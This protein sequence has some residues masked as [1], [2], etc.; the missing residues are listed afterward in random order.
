MTGHERGFRL[1]LRLLPET[2]RQAYGEEMTELFLGRLGRARAVGRRQVVRLWIRTGL[3]VVRTAAAER[4]DGS[5]GAAGGPAGAIRRGREG[6]ME[7]LAQD[8]R[9][10]ARRLARTP[11]FTLAA[12]A[13]LAMGIGANAAAFALVDGLLFRPPPFPRPAELVRV[14]QDGDDGEPS[15]T[16]FP[17]YRDM[18]AA[19]DVFAAVSATSPDVAAWEG[20]EGPRPVAVEYATA[21]HF[22]VLG[23]EPFRGR[24]F[25]ASH[26][27]P[28][29][30]N[31]AVV[32]HW[33]WTHR[34]GADPGVLGSTVRINGQPVTVIGVGP[35]G[36][37][38]VGQALVT[39]FWL[40][41]SSAGVGGP[42][43]IANLDRREDHWYDVSARLAPGATPAA[44]QAAMDALAGRLAEAW[45][46]LNRGRDITVFR[47]GEVRL[48]PEFDG[49][50]RAAGLGLLVVVGLV[51]V[52]ACSNLANLLLVRGLARSSE[53]AV[54][55][56]LG[57]GRRRVARL[58]LAE[59]LLL[60]GLGGAVGLGVAAALVGALPRLPLPLPGGAALDVPLDGRFL[61]FAVAL[62]LAT[63]VLFGLAPALRSTRMDPAGAL[64]EVRS[65]G[66]G[67]TVSLVRA[68][69]V[70]VQVAVSVVLVVG[71]AL[72]A[73][74]LGS[75]SSVEPGFDVERLAMIGTNLAQGGLS[76]AE[77]P[78]VA[79]ELVRRVA[80]LPGVDRVALTSRLPVQAGGSTTTVIEGYAPPSGTGAV[81]LPFAVVS[82]D[83]FETMGIRRLAGRGFG[84]DDRPGSP[85]VVVVNET[86]ARRF[87]GGDAVGGR[88][89]PEGQPNAWR[90]VVG[91]VADVKVSGLQEPPTPML[92]MAAAQSAPAAFTV[93][94]RTDGDPAA[95]APALRRALGAVRPGLPV[96]RLGTLDD[97]LGRALVG[98]RAV[99]GLLGTF[100]LLALLLASLGIY[101]VVAFSVARRAGEMGIRV[102][103]GAPRR[104]LVRM[105][106]REALVP[107]AAGLAVG[108]AAA[109][110]AAR[111]MD[112]LLF[113][114]DAL[115]PLAFG[116][117]L[118]LLLAA[119]ILASWLPARRAAGADPL[120]ALRAR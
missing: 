8:V 43:R 79:E 38:G 112:A 98:P 17:A 93:V 84:P 67:R 82:G 1:L 80:A 36:Y 2:F 85:S 111:L 6:T 48:H 57:A 25:D 19:T 91:V 89:R 90:E 55:R 10:A 66:G 5:D 88:V 70:G 96:T 75:A 78:V 68:T 92:Y 41:I 94:A 12:V 26:D 72:M 113:G 119:A 86:A 37:G 23:I 100:S 97:H 35:Q 65:P 117:G 61:A 114:V 22:P 20:P 24:W 45:P 83:Y 32:S 54:R 87:W 120:E 63:G 3:D 108:L 105:V 29:A 21:S 101:A 116:G 76:A 110:A 59:S 18:A 52:L 64:R 53:V 47:F 107:V 31:V 77:A 106:L 118:A 99:T 16:S 71:A 34:M 28:G 109:V 115:D 33:T 39:D 14:Y 4:R 42:S 58:F 15:A 50:L 13:I 81:E 56:A 49:P 30:G 11:L 95:L 7:T 73:R 74:S 44:A 69:L 46:E 40:S 60:A 62:A 102:A 104:R 9:H 103:L 51:L 27:V